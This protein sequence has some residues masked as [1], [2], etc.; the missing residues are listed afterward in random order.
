M[1]MKNSRHSREGANAYYRDEDGERVG[2]KMPA[3]ARRDKY[4]KPID[5][6]YSEDDSDYDE[7]YDD[8]D[9]DQEGS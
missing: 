8:F 2:N 7:Q 3:Y 1:S 4:R 6:M 9:S 5:M